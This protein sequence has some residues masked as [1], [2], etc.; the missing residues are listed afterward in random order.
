[1]KSSNSEPKFEIDLPS[2]HSIGGSAMKA[3]KIACDE[4]SKGDLDM[5]NFNISISEEIDSTNLG[6]DDVFVVTFL[7]KLSPGKRGLGT[8][9]R[10]PGSVT[11]FISKKK[12]KI[13]KEQGI[14]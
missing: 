7:G 13:I 10:A 11:Y 6:G 12:W 5:Q 14:R 1:M 2:A 3:L 8:A 9:N 4:F